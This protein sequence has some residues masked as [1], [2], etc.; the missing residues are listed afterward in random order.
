MIEIRHR[1]PEQAIR[2]AFYSLQT[3]Y[4]TSKSVIEF[5]TQDNEKYDLANRLANK[6]GGHNKFLEAMPICLIIRAPRYWWQ[7][8]DTYRI[9]VTKSSQSTMHTILKQPLTQEDF[10]VPIPWDYLDKLNQLR[11]VGDL[12]TLKALLPEGFMQLRVLGTNYKVLRH[13]YHQRKTH[14]L[15]EWKEF[16]KYIESEL[17]Y[18]EWLTGGSICNARVVEEILP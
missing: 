14:K 18:S 6:D 4:D 17:P 2:F 11:E 12:L 8:A 7:E 16:C 1:L 9:G 10:A 5:L 15:P 3:S 13:I